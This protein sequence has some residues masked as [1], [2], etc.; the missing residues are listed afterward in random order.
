MIMQWQSTKMV[1]FGAGAITHS[2]GLACLKILKVLLNQ[3]WSHALKNSNCKQLRFLAAKI[4]AWSLQ[5]INKVTQGSTVSEKMRVIIKI[6]VALRI[7]LKLTLSERFL[8]WQILRSKISMLTLVI[9]WLSFKVTRSQLMDST[10]TVFQRTNQ[11]QEFY[12]HTNKMTSGCLCQKTSTRKIISNYLMFVWRLSV[13]FQTWI[14]CLT[15]LSPSFLQIWIH[16]Q[17]ETN[18]LLPASH[19]RKWMEFSTLQVQRWAL[20]T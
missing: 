20:K 7:K 9:P 2:A 10:S 5:R 14:P 16:L 11:L 1:S 17:E 19:I 12:T 18:R 4:I 13:K 3:R 8:T 6:L 15:A